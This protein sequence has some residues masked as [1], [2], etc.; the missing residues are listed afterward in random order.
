MRFLTLAGAVRR[1]LRAQGLIKVV[2]D[3]EAVHGQIT[4]AELRAAKRRQHPRK[5]RRR[6]G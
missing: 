2:R 5:P 4:V 6:D 3:W 1:R